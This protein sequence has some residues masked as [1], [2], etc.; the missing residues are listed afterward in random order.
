MCVFE[1]YIRLT[2]PRENHP[3]ALQS[4]CARNAA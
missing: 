4:L 3:S 2:P 1:R